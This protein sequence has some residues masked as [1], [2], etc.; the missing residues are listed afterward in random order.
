ML[1]YIVVGIAVISH[2][3]VV[4][5]LET[6]VHRHI[7]VQTGSLS[8]GKKKKDTLALV[9]LGIMQILHSKLLN[10]VEVNN[11]TGLMIFK[12]A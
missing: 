11:I 5:H 10:G 6:A 12:T 2:C 9:Y 7:L 1:L 8:W 4:C 3:W